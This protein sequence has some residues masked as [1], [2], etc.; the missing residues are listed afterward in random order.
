MTQEQL[1]EIKKEY[2]VNEDQDYYYITFSFEELM[3]EFTSKYPDIKFTKF[4]NYIRIKK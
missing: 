4:S 3:D 1:Q 2:M